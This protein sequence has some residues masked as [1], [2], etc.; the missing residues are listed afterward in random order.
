MSRLCYLKTAAFE[1][2][3]FY[4][5][6]GYLSKQRAKIIMN[7]HGTQAVVNSFSM[8]DV[9][10]KTRLE[11]FRLTPDFAKDPKQ[12]TGRFINQRTGK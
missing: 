12:R 7:I 5:Q 3:L 6:P 8:G 1:P 2:R 4:R 10:G 11:D 9:F